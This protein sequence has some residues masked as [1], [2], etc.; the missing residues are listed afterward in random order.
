MQLLVA[1]LVDIGMDKYPSY[2]FCFFLFLF[3]LFLSSLFLSLSFSLF[4]VFLHN[5][6]LIAFL[7]SL[8]LSFSLFLSQEFCER[9]WFD[10]TSCNW[11]SFLLYR[12]RF[13]SCLFL[14]FLLFLFFSTPLFLLLSFSFFSSLLILLSLKKRN[15]Q[16]NSQKIQHLY[17]YTQI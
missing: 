14:P 6:P 13:L 15:S 2:Q 8:S 17:Q 5:I 1:P 10:K 4:L 16:N 3:F 9:I 12:N 11:L 7:F